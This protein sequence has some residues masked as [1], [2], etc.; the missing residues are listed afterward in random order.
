MLKETKVIDGVEYHNGYYIAERNIGIIEG[1]L[2]TLAELLGL[3]TEQKEALKA[4]IRQIIWG[5]GFLS[6]GTTITAEKAA[7]MLAQNPN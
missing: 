4:E 2:L 5:R 1:R 6:Y 7:E 3:P